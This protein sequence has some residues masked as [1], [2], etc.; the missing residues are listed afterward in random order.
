M[1]ILHSQPIY[2]NL[3]IKQ[4]NTKNGYHSPSLSILNKK[5][6]NIQAQSEYID[7]NIQ[8]CK[9]LKCNSFP[10]I[11]FSTQEIEVSFGI[12]F[13]QIIKLSQNQTV[14]KN[15]IQLLN[16]NQIYFLE[17]ILQILFLKA[18][19]FKLLANC[20]KKAL[21]MKN[22]QNLGILYFINVQMVNR[23]MNQMNK[24]VNIKQCCMQLIKTQL[25]YFFEQIMILNQRQNLYYL[26]T[27]ITINKISN[28]LNSNQNQECPICT[29]LYNVNQ[30]NLTPCCQKKLHKQCIQED[31][32]SKAK[33]NKNFK[34]IKC[35]CN[36]EQSLENNEEFIRKILQN[37]F[38]V[39]SQKTSISKHSSKMLFMHSSS[40][41]SNLEFNVNKIWQLQSCTQFWLLKRILFSLFY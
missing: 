29:E 13:Y 21:Y 31:L 15:F 38:L 33:E 34:N 6:W 12:C 28:S 27:R 11:K 16:Y 14:R 37:K 17:R 2:Q 18:L 41:L 35:C 24:I 9:F 23:L 3:N 30:T 20:Q 10:I 26:K 36:C 40:C 32:C 8:N 22:M 19:I 25:T 7:L 4:L 39:K 1:Y 5:F